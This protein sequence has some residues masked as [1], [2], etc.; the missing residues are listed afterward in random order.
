MK[1]DLNAAPNTQIGHRWGNVVK[2]KPH[3]HTTK[4]DP[5]RGNNYE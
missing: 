5:K 1:C 4:K 2:T 3:K